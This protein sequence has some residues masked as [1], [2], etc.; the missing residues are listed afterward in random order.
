LYL[1]GIFWGHRETGT[2]GELL[3]DLEEDKGARTVVFGLL[4]GMGR[5]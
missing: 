1:F 5:K 3:I 4:A 2:F